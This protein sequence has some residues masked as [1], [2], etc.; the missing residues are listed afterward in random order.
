LAFDGDELHP[1]GVALGSRMRP[2]KTTR[3]ESLVEMGQVQRVF[4]R[5][6]FG[7]PGT[8]LMCLV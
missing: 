3:R 4:T 2:K 1:L 7:A 6:E 8:G 5:A